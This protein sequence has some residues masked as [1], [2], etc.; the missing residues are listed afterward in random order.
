[1]RCG[2]VL[3]W[4]DLRVTRNRRRKWKRPEVSRGGDRRGEW[5]KK[6]EGLRGNEKAEVV[7]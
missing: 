2:V 7:T 6:G 3:G 5:W 1:M 4:G